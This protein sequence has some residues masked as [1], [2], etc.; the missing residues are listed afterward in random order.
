MNDLIRYILLLIV[1]YLGLGVGI[2]ISHMAK[3]EIKPGQKYFIILKQ[4]I[5]CIIFFYF[6]SYLKLQIFI[7]LPLVVLVGTVT[8]FLLEQIKHLNS[9]LFFYIFFSIIIFETRTSNVAPIL[10][11][12][13]FMFGV[14]VSSIK[15]EKLP[16]NL[17]VKLK[18]SLLNNILYI[19]LGL[20]LLFVFKV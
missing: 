10:F 19:L 20:A 1:S 8:Y 15:S 14:V 17:F 18:K 4:L 2:V 7:S 5:F 12:L 3:E 11:T 16:E 6:L 13:I 9:D